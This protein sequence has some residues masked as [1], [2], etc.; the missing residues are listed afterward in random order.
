MGDTDD[1]R[2]YARGYA[3]E[4]DALRLEN[5]L[6][7]EQFA[8]AEDAR[9]ALAA[10][11]AEVEAERDA[12]L[13]Q[14]A[15]VEA[16]NLRLRDGLAEIAKDPRDDSVCIGEGWDFYTDQ[17]MYAREIIAVPANATAAL[18]ALQAAI[19]A[20]VAEARAEDAAKIEALVDTVKRM[21]AACDAMWND[22]ER[23]EKNAG[24]FAGQQ[25]WQLKDAHMRA[26]SEAQQ[27]SC[28]ILAQIGAK[29]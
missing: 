28:I 2:A 10:S 25:P 4:R 29:P 15:V 17:V 9:C 27:D 18:T 16:D 5:L 14:V 19:D 7:A 22:H 24:Y 23:L 3:A 8:Q 12:A 13:A 1:K 21:N 6:L 26:I 11:L 20:A